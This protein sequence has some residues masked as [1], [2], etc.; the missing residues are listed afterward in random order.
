MPV[1]RCYVSDDTLRI[2]ERECQRRGREET[3]EHLAE[4]AIADAAIRAVPP[5]VRE[6]FNVNPR[7]EPTRRDD[8]HYDSQGYCDNPGRGY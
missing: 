7:R 2:L 6:N 8:W 1:L 4:N 3:P 5:P